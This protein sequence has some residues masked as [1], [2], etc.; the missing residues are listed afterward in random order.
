MFN[1]IMLILNVRI[2]F[3]L[4][5]N[6]RY[7]DFPAEYEQIY[8]QLFSA[9]LS[10]PAFEKLIEISYVRHATPNDIFYKQG[11]L[12]TT[13]SVLISGRVHVARN[14]NETDSQWINPSKYIAVGP[15]SFDPRHAG[16]GGPGRGGGFG[17]GVGGGRNR[18]G[19][20]IGGINI[21]G[22]E[23]RQDSNTDRDT[24][25]DGHMDEELSELEVEAGSESFHDSVDSTIGKVLSNPNSINVCYENEFIEAP[26]W[27]AAGLNPEKMRIDTELIA[28]ENVTYIKWPRENLV[29]LIQRDYDIYV[30][31]Q[32]VLGLQTAQLLMR[33]REFAKKIKNTRQD[34]VAASVNI[35]SPVANIQR[36]SII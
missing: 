15:S 34:S 9:Y 6:R 11:D 25:R 19:A 23:H 26:Q 29:D 8:T 18:S 17:G 31:I 12:V 14:R 32:S 5:Y 10:R 21:A 16:H 3:I 7:I 36:A 24:D 33:S 27:V 1:F 22:A 2:A 20:I 35:A 28:L 13:L 4:L 30:A